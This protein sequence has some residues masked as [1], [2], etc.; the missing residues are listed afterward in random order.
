MVSTPLFY[1]LLLVALGLICLLMHVVW[2]DDPSRVS[3]P[4]PQPPQ[5]RRRHVKELNPF[6]GFVHKP[7]CA[8]WAQAADAQPKAPGFPPPIIRSTR[9]RRRTV[10]THAH[11]CPEPDCS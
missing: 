8:A 6:P 3:T 11:C 2:P 7:L 4:S 10:G 9:G 5:H 1:Q